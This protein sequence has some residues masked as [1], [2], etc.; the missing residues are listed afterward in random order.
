MTSR[1]VTVNS[2]DQGRFSATFEVQRLL[3]IAGTTY[4]C[5]DPPVPGDRAACNLVAAPLASATENGQVPLYFDPDAPLVERA[6][7]SLGQTDGLVDFQVVD[8]T[9]TDP[10]RG[11]WAVNQCVTADTGPRCIGSALLGQPYRSLQARDGQIDTRIVVRRWIGDIDCMAEGIRCSIVG[12]GLTSGTAGEI[13]GQRIQFAEG[14]L[15]PPIALRA[16]RQTVAAQGALRLAADGLVLGQVDPWLCTTGAVAADTCL[17]MWQSNASVSPTG[18][19]VLVEAPTDQI[20]T[21]TGPIVGCGAP[22]ACEVVL[23]DVH[24]RRR[25]ASTPI[26]VTASV[27][28]K[29]PGSTTFSTTGNVIPGS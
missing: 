22:G 24:D 13:L 15:A 17:P 1:F 9:V 28:S 4:D 3:A 6:A 10:D 21:P 18:T 5:I 7:I 14:S 26:V 23:F 25:I 19:V 16:D 8:V 27:V 2:D 20:R 11:S 29:L 12:E